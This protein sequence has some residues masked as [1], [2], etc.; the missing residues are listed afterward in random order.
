MDN[1]YVLHHI[2]QKEIRKKG[3]RIFG[4]FMDL[5]S[6]FDRVD[7]KVLQKAMERRGIR[8]GIERI[9][10]IYESTKKRC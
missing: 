10:E 3:E 5:K 2:K 1:I 6:V 8:K 7:R 9:K 4:F